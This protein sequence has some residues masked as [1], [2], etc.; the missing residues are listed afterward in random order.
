MHRANPPKT[1]FRDVATFMIIPTDKSENFNINYDEV[2]SEYNFPR[3]P[4]VEINKK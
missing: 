2:Q 4:W 3:N 1:G